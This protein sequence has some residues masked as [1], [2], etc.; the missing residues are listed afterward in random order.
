MSDNNED[1]A[2]VT[3]EITFMT[4]EPGGANAPGI[5]WTFDDEGENTVWAGPFE[6]EEL[7]LENA[8]HALAAA[9]VAAANQ[10]FGE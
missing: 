2:T 7:A 10:L 1:E 5:Y 4:V 6:T 3:S 9:Y 8:Q